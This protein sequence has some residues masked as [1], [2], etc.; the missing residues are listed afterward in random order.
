MKLIDSSGSALGMEYLVPLYTMITNTPEKASAWCVCTGS[1]GLIGLLT[2]THDVGW[3]SKNR[4][5]FHRDFLFAV[6][7]KFLRGSFPLFEALWHA[8]TQK[9]LMKKYKAPYC[10]IQ[11]LCVDSAYQNRGLGRKL[12][13]AVFHTCQKNVVNTVYVDTLRSNIQAQRFYKSVGFERLQT[14]GDSVLFV[15]TIVP[16]DRRN[17]R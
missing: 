2:C 16:R 12:L 1:G 10:S 11:A 4:R 17:R 3:Y 14:I 8:R 7:G 6:I 15:K 5:L 13:E 9:K